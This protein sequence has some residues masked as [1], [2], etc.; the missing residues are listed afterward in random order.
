[1]PLATIPYLARVLGVAGWGLV[2]FSQAFGSYVT[3][4]GDYAFAYSATREV[5]RHRE[6]REKLAQ[7]TGGVL[8]AKA[9][10][11][12]SAVALALLVRAWVPPLRTHPLLFW[13]V[14][15]WAASQAASMRWFFRGL[16]RMQLLATV[17][18]SARVLGLVGIFIFVHGPK[19][20]WCVFAVQGLCLFLSFVVC[21][22]LACH[23]LPL[24]MP[25]RAHVWEALRMGRSLFLFEGSVTLYTIANT[26]VL[27]LFAPP[28]LVGFYAGAEKIVRAA[29][30]LLDPITQT[31]YPRLSHLVWRAPEEAA[32]LST[33]GAAITVTGGA[34]L[35]AASFFLAPELVRVLLGPGY[36]PAVPILKILAL[37]PLVASFSTAL[38][39]Q[40]GLP[41]GLERPINVVTAVAGL[42]DIGLAV[43][44]ARPFAGIGMA[45]V[46]VTSELFVAGGIYFVLRIRGLAP[47]TGT[48]SQQQLWSKREIQ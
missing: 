24:R 38:G 22:A 12:S 37:L 33:I 14:M 35:S 16:E 47:L 45:W 17:E 11:I 34:A 4:V 13:W 18:I 40:W 8:G 42:I 31:L 25:T 43:C 26:T 19:D 23:G 27:G 41:L 36:G 21:T 39:T 20:E 46:A 32:R 10:L 29:V 15:F 30:R 44:L 6:N 7:I 3:L 2:A 1:M 5:A 48:V 9:L 28:E